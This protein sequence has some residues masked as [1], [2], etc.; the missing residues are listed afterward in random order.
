MK[1][2]KSI[3]IFNIL[4]KVG[5]EYANTLNFFVPIKILF[6]YFAGKMSYTIGAYT[7]SK[8]EIIFAAGIIFLLSVICSFVFE[9]INKK[10]VIS[11]ANEHVKLHKYNN[12]KITW[13]INL[14]K[15]IIDFYSGI[16]FIMTLLLLILILY[17]SSIIPLS[18]LMIVQILLYVI[19][20]KTKLIQNKNIVKFF[21]TNFVI[22]KLPMMN[23]IV[24]SIIIIFFKS[25]VQNNET[26]FH[27]K[28]LAIMIF[29]RFI[30][31]AIEK[32]ILLD[33]NRKQYLNH[34]YQIV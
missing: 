14:Y 26:F 30:F 9:G 8:N 13:F 29:S 15:T 17:Y 10:I 19:P 28:L 22:S 21:E 25:D 4:S 23:W 24:Y 3:L 34:N 18:F 16:F 27:L 31:Q 7:L 11:K 1:L 33:K 2:K 5:I 32:L 6:I 20:V 12:N